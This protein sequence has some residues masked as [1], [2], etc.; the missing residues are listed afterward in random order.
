MAS[1]RKPRNSR[2][3]KACFTLPSAVPGE[4]GRQVQR[5]TRRT[6]KDEA[7]QVALSYEKTA[8]LARDRRF[9]EA[10]ARRFLTEVRAVTGI[11]ANHVIG[12]TEFCQRW[13]TGTARRLKAK[14][15]Q[16]YR[17]S[18]TSF[19]G[20][21]GPAAA[22]APLADLSP[23]EVTLWRD[24]LLVSGKTETTANLMLAHV[25]QVMKAAKLQ[26]LI[27]TNPCDGLRFR[28][29]DAKRQ[30]RDAFTQE[31]FRALV[32]AAEGEWRTLVLVLALTGARQQEG[33]QLRWEQVDFARGRITLVRGKQNDQR[34]VVPL[35]SRL[36]AH[37]EAVRSSSVFV[38][39]GIA[40]TEGRNLSNYFRRRLLPKIGIVQPYGGRAG[41]KVLA[42]YSLHSL[43]HSL[44][45]WLDETGATP[46]ERRALLGHETA[47]INEGYTHAALDRVATALEK[48]GA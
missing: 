48:V 25:S 8:K 17:E 15:A 26:H 22:A 42:K 20:A 19:L 10:A 7:L 11:G 14:T 44:S 9:T 36:R 39:P 30:R 32:A 35:H 38:M 28:K 29:A 18:L 16:R 37:L 31:Q 4:P 27:E 43:R 2:Y 5:S 24:S 21:L 23:T 47:A 33:A 46:A 6:D 34:H 12:A 45:S 40:A 3:W 1:V 41:G 13:L